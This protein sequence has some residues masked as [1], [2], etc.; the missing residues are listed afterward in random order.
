MSTWIHSD[1]N[2]Y[3]TKVGG[4]TH[5]SKL[6]DNV[7]M[8]IEKCDTSIAQAFLAAIYSIVDE[9]PLNVIGAAQINHQP[10][11]VFFSRLRQSITSK[12]TAS[13][14]IIVDCKAGRTL[15]GATP[16]VSRR[17]SGRRCARVSSIDTCSVKY[18][19]FN[20]T[21]S[22]ETRNRHLHSLYKLV[23]RRLQ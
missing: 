17:L 22:R 3:D 4:I 14:C 12:S 16:E 15:S 5:I 7:V 23:E 18:L 11:I 13:A 8:F 19:Q 20:N 2:L 21:E 9:H 1:N 6:R 10:W